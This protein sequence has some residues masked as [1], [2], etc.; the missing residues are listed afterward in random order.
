[1]H[2]EQME[3]ALKE[4]VKELN[5]RLDETQEREAKQ[6]KKFVEKAVKSYEVR[7]THPP[8]LPACRYN[9][10]SCGSEASTH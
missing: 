3:K 6:A 1:M 9:N 2:F 7:Q 5:Q 4:Q 8:G 10:N